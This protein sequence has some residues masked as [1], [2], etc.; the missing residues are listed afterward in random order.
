MVRSGAVRYGASFVISL[1]L[2]TPVPAAD[3][4]DVVVTPTAYGAIEA[5]QINKGYYFRRGNVDATPIAH[6][7]QQRAIANIGFNAL[8]KNRL[9]IN[10]IGEGL[11]AFSS[12]QIST[13][14]QTLQTRQFFYIKSAYASYPFGNI[15]APFFTLQAGFFQYKYNPDARNLGEYLFRSNAYPLVIYSGFDYPMADIFGFRANVRLKD[16]GLKDGLL[17]N[18]LI[19]HSELLGVPVQDWSIADIVSYSLSGFATVGAG[20]SFSRFFSVYQGTY[21][22]LTTDPYFY[23]NNLPAAEKRNFYIFDTSGTDS[24]LFDW[25]AIKLMARASF[26]AKKFIAFDMLGREDLKVYVEADLIGLKSYPQIFDNRKERMLTTFGLNLPA[27]GY[28]DLVNVEVEY[29]PNKSAFSD[30]NLYGTPDMNVGNIAPLDSFCTGGTYTV[31]RS[32]W[33]WSVYLK[34]SV[35]GGHVSFIAQCAR[36]HKKIDF[37]YFELSNMSFMETLQAKKDW[38]WSLKT[39]FK[40]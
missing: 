34:R 2:Y 7:W 35:L 39:E 19:L 38:W 25:K 16:L 27:F 21:P 4:S 28:C 26:D 10:F 32:P 14:P 31:K 37:Y 1:F 5:G 3:N 20:V 6:L 9:T 29:C 33:R 11:M 23:P 17:E 24:A 12:P 15:E 36:D 40:F 30:G 8:V 18:D 22:S 13:W